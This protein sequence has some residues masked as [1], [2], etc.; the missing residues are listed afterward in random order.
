MINPSAE[1]KTY[2]SPLSLLLSIAMSYKHWGISMI[3]WRTYAERALTLNYKHSH[4]KSH[5]TEQHSAGTMTSGWCVQAPWLSLICL[6]VRRKVFLIVLI[7][8]WGRGCRPISTIALC[9]FVVS[10]LLHHLFWLDWLDNC[11]QQWVEKTVTFQTKWPDTQK[12]ISWASFCIRVHND[13]N[14]IVSMYRVEK[15]QKDKN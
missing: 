2:Y 7:G 5:T 13:I 10:E 12:S 8:Q 3:L 9:L 14:T 6:A 1:P 4:I 11:F 15:V